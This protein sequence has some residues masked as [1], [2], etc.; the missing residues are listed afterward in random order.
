MRTA[1]GVDFE[2]TI[3]L[4]TI[5]VFTMLNPRQVTVSVVM[6]KE[7]YITGADHSSRHA[8]LSF[9]RPGGKS[10]D[11]VVDLA[12]M[13]FGPK[14]RGSGGETFRMET[15]DKWLDFTSTVC[16]NMQ[17]YKIGSAR[18]LSH[19]WGEPWLEESAKRVKARWDARE[20]DHWCGYCGALGAEK[21]CPCH[22]V[23]YCSQDHQ[24]AGWK[25]HKRFCSTKK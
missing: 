23:W 11:V 17:E 19:P 16:G 2:T 8:I 10:A 4:R 18:I 13:Q 14:G 15:M 25:F 5:L 3:S 7:T 20:T 1:S 12:S 6:S 21:R 24:K 9:V 22:D